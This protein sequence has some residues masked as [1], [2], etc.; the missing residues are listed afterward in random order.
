MW[1]KP[2]TRSTVCSCEAETPRVPARRWSRPF[3]QSR[4]GTATGGVTGAGA[5]A[6]GAAGAEGWAMDCAP[7]AGAAP[8]FAA[9]AGEEACRLSSMAAD[10]ESPPTGASQA[11]PL[12]T[13]CRRHWP[14]S[15]W[16]TRQVLGGS[17][18]W[19]SKALPCPPA[20]A[21]T[22]SSFQAPAAG[23]SASPAGLAAGEST[24]QPFAGT[25]ARDPSW[26]RATTWLGRYWPICHH[27]N[28]QTTRLAAAAIHSSRA[29]PAGSIRAGLPA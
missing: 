13:R 25:S 4:P 24:R 23:V 18:A 11:R 10:A 14:S 5:G 28:P 27:R 6:T 8:G 26:P 17:P 2:T 16:P 1:R 22:P 21:T 19:L 12:A 3:A 20:A 7:P 9:G 29:R 15:D